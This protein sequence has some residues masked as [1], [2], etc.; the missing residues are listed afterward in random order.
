MHMKKTLLF[1]LFV[2]PLCISCL[3]Q[4]VYAEERGAILEKY[5]NERFA[6]TQKYHELLAKMYRAGIIAFGDMAGANAEMAYFEAVFAAIKSRDPGLFNAVVKE[7]VRRYNILR[8]V[9]PG[10]T[11]R[12]IEKNREIYSSL[13]EEIISSYEHGLRPELEVIKIKR[14]ITDLDFLYTVFVTEKIDL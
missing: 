4:P 5:I 2:L 7:T 14:I 1:V 11:R 9:D 3:S 6:L 13:A 10:I 12:Q 8:G